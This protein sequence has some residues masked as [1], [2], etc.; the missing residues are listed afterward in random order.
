MGSGSGAVSGF[1][2][3]FWLGL[4]VW[5]GFGIQVS[6]FRRGGVLGL[7]GV[8]ITLG[9]LDRAC[10]GLSFFLRFLLFLFFSL[11]FHVIRA[12]VYIVPEEHLSHPV[13]FFRGGEAG[14]A[15]GFGGL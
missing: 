4:P 3:E 12:G 13:N 2:F 7:G 14:V 5:G 15:T 10:R 1:G 6:G 9:R 8:G 11:S